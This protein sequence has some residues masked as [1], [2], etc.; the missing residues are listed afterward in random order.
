MLLKTHMATLGDNTTLQ[1]YHPVLTNWITQS[2]TT[3]VR[4]QAANHAPLQRR[5]TPLLYDYFKESRDRL[6]PLNDKLRDKCALAK[7]DSANKNL[8]VEPQ[9]GSEWNEEWPMK[10]EQTVSSFLSTFHEDDVKILSEVAG[11]V[12][13]VIMQHTKNPNVSITLSDDQKHVCLVGIKDTV[14]LLKTTVERIIQDNLDDMQEVE[15]PLNVLVFLNEVVKEDLQQEHKQVIF[16]ANLQT[17]TLHVSGKSVTCKAFLE[18]VNRLH[19][20]YVKAELPL[21]IVGLLSKPSGRQMLYSQ[22]RA[23]KGVS[24]YFTDD[25]GRIPDLAAPATALYIVGRSQNPA[26]KVAKALQNTLIVENITVPGEFRHTV[27]MESWTKKHSEIEKNYVAAVNPLLDRSELQIVCEKKYS[28]EIKRGL[29]AFMLSECFAEAS[30]S[31]ERGQW[32]YL[33]KYSDSWRELSKK[34]ETS[35]LE[36]RY[37]DSHHSPSIFLK[38]E[39]TPV[40]KLGAAV[41][42]LRDDIIKDKKEVVRPGAVKHFLSPAGKLQIKGI[43]AELEAVVQVSTLEEQEEENAAIEQELDTA[44]YQKVLSGTIQGGK[45]VDIMTGDLT[46]LAVDVIVNAANKH[47]NHGSGIAGAIVRKGGKVIQEDCTQYVERHG[48]LEVGDAVIMT[49]PG[50]LRCKAVVHAVG[51]IWHDE[52]EK[53]EGYIIKAVFESIKQAASKRFRSIG[54]PAISTGIYHVPVDI[55]A[56]AMFRGVEKFFREDPSSDMK[57]TIILFQKEHIR[58]FSDAA[59]HHLQNVI[60][61]ELK[62]R[63]AHTSQTKLLKKPSGGPQKV[64]TTTPT[65]LNRPRLPTKNVSP[66]IVLK[67]GKLTDCQVRMHNCF[68]GWF[69]NASLWKSHFCILYFDSHFLK[70]LICS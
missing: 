64:K 58:V 32:E 44:P 17:S 27:R 54:F 50:N 18:T 14:Q 33:Y 2:K 40:K 11:K 51:P 68:K 57:V 19:P 53:S 3:E 5:M 62:S 35:S 38:G 52:K 70:T 30:I 56:R 20:F 42:S 41:R 16:T 29:L 63:K 23:Q 36:Y 25:Q 13:P 39:A 4:H 61:S 24:H 22:I 12:F 15:L 21:P 7:L 69:V 43:G 55:C 59:N 49:N 34:I 1:A 46:E 48:E 37:P 10:C 9:D 45:Q 47:L 26:M 67:K 8:L 60:S 6:D 65:T 28:Q 66:A 31:L